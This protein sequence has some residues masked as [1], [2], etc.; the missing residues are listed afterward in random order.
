MQWEDCLNPKEESY[1]LPVE[2]MGGVLMP[3]FLMSFLGM[4]TPRACLLLPH[5]AFRESEALLLCA[6][7]A[8]SFLGSA[9]HTNLVNVVQ[10]QG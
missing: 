10:N 4:P 2:A 5:R 6:L 8:I 7:D 9:L 3:F 1:A